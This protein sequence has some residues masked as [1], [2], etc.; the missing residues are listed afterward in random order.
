MYCLVSQCIVSLSC[1]A[2]TMIIC[3]GIVCGMYTPSSIS[4]TVQQFQNPYPRTMTDQAPPREKRTAPVTS[5][6][7]NALIAAC[8]KN[9]RFKILE[10]DSVLPGDLDNPIHPIFCRLNSDASMN[11]MLRLASQFITLDTLLEFFVPL[12]YGRELTTTIDGT[13]KT[14]L[15]DPLANVTKEKI[16][17]YVAGV[18]E[19][20][21]CLGH[22]L[23]FD[24]TP[25]VKGVYAR[26]IR[27]PDIP[28]H[29]S[30]CCPAF[31]KESSC[32]IEISNYCRDYYTKDGYAA[33]SRCAQFRHDFLWAVT[34]VHEIVHAVGV[35][36]RG[37]LTEPHIRADNPNNEWG[38][39][40]EHFMFGNI[41]NPQTRTAVGTHYFMRRAWAAPQA[42]EDAG[43]KEYCGV[44]MSYIAQW[45]R[46][47]TWDIIDEQ[48]PTAIP[49]PI[50]RFKVQPSNKVGA[51]VVTS[52]CPEAEAD[53]RT[54]DHEWE[55]QYQRSRSSSPSS[56]R[57][58]DRSSGRSSHRSSVR[59]SDR[60]SDRSSARTSDRSSDRSSA[61][62]SARSSV[63]SLGHHSVRSS[64]SA[65][66]QAR[67]RIVFRLCTRETLQ[68]TNLPLVVRI[69]ERVQQCLSCGHTVPVTKRSMV[70]TAPGP[71]HV[72]ATNTVV[73]VCRS[74]SPSNSSGS[75]KRRAESS[76]E[77][78]RATELIK[79]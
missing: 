68:N 35:L 34:I 28:T 29:T 65:A 22:S 27:W 16:K 8:N 67:D 33:A 15:S 49:Q 38:F 40:W 37:N 17:E 41:M 51:W 11:Q 75:R 52:D 77:R 56:D 57:S 59:S 14:C 54:L 74:S 45:F 44:P 1:P 20:L 39:G 66:R 69:P 31:Q 62:S 63:R 43:G 25:P 61:R 46:K 36:R 3:H 72:V 9:D 76:V 79:Q 10:D 78:G 7:I 73:A 23:S 6:R 12:L 4:R 24:Y 32:K 50:A 26:T 5:S 19:A 55:Q 13:R 47:E 53:L 42:I 70:A 58:S 2:F 21:H 30:T 71:A 18:R 64:T 48:G 60:S